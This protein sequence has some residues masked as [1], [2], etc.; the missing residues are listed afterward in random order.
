MDKLK[1]VKAIVQINS[2]GILSIAGIAVLAAFFTA[3]GG[4][5][6]A[7]N[8]ASGG[9]PAEVAAT[10]NGKA[11][12]MQDVD[13]GV[14]Q[15]AQGQEGKL[16][17]LELA[18][19]RL[20]VLQTLVEEEVM[21]QKAE[22]E[23]KIPSDEEV[24]G[25]INKRKTASGLSVEEFDKQLTQAGLDEKSFREK[26]KKGLAIQQLLDK[27]T[28][29]IETPKDKEITDFFNSNPEMFVKKRGVRLAAIVIDPS[30][31]GQGDLTKN[32]TEAQQKVQEVVGKVSQPASDFAALAREYS[33]DGSKAQGGDLGYISEES[34]KQ[35]FGEQIS[36]A[37]MNPSFAVGKITNA[38]PLNGKAYIFK[39]QERIEKDETLTLESPEVRPQIQQNLVDTR[40][41]LLG[42]SYQA[43][44]MN[45]AK[46]VNNLAKKVVDNPNELSGARPAGSSTPANTNANTAAANTNANAANANAAS[47]A[48]AKPVAN[49]NAAKPAANAPAAAN[50]NKVK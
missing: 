45:E 15:Q 21:F 24:T 40:K 1:G 17:Q 3:C 2:K 30:D 43:M 32:A 31:S 50:T 4:G 7:G 27:V 10:V 42:A 22:K 33:E 18:G 49:A 8:S 23:G 34:L 25:E 13:R 12:S 35:N 5:P 36:A 11:I 38:I 29:R 41:Q 16:S 48:N 46:I 26:I 9:D 14:K 19:A 37:F 6:T 44:A 39:L 47:N 20:Q 28:A